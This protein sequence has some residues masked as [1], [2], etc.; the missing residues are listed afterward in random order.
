LYRA[1]EMGLNTTVLEAADGLGGTWYHN[2][3]PGCRFDS[4]SYTYG[5]SFSD[6]LL[7]EWDWSEHF[8]S[9][10]ENLRYLN[11]VADKFDLRRHMQFGAKARGARFDEASSA[12]TVELH[13]GRTI[14]SRFVVTAV[15][16]LSRP[17]MPRL[18]GI[19]RFEGPWFHTYQWPHEGIDLTGK[20]VAV[21]GTG[22]TAVQLIP[23]VA[24]TAGEL[25]VFQRHPN[26]CAPLHNRPITPEEMA[27][28]RARYDEI[29]ALCA[30]TPGGFIH[31]ADRRNLGEV[32]EA[33][34]YAFFEELYA[35]S[36]FRIWQGNFRD[37]LLVE[38]ANEEFTAFVAGK[39]RDR[40]NDPALAEKL[41]PKDHGFGT[42]RVPMET[43]YY[44]AYNQPNV[45]LVDLNETPITSITETGVQTSD[46]TY[47][48][49]VIVYATGFDAVTGAFDAIEFVGVGGQTLKEKWA[50]G[51]VT[52]LG[53]QTAGFPNLLMVAGPQAGSGFTN[54]GRGIEEAVDWLTTLLEH[55]RA[56]GV[57]RI[58]TTEEAEREWVQ[59]VRDLYDMVLLGKVKSWF[60]GYNSNLDDRDEMRPVAYN[61]GAPRI[62]MRLA[63]VAEQG[64][65]GFV[66]T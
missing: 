3:Y 53:I 56:E 60:T 13:D 50:K 63:E 34:R 11:H 38:E 39:I 1:V 59:H 54:F 40:V 42:R 35:S 43:G 26:W 27:D 15:G 57:S 49:D 62:R 14:R 51:P 55:L 48:V 23:R 29:F 10:P 12:W 25:F 30:K 9:Q 33:E 20:R 2:R 58:D 19:D 8:S 37:V 24:E 21:I 61:G 4:E 46:T 41:V 5:Y 16:I 65:D 52:Y 22:A 36:G 7:D 31:R 47:E 64:Y 45:H 18:E 44:E 6:E 17:T 28:I 32:A 66:L